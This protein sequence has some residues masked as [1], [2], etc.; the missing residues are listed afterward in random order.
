MKETELDKLSIKQLQDLKLRVDRLISSRHENERSNLREKF[1]SMAEQAGFSL[2]D[3]VGTMRQTKSRVSGAKAK[4]AAKYANPKDP[5]QTW[6]GRGRMP[7]WLS[8][9]VKSGA[10]VTDFRI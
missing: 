7:N 2:Q 10:K 1:R 8:E 4:V 9:R 5:T 6:S 3:I